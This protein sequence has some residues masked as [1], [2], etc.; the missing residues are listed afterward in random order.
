MHKYRIPGGV[1]V[2][3]DVPPDP[4]SAINYIHR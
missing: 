3:M 4:E 2:G 1:E